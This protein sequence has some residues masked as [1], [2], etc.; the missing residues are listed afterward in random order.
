MKK[1]YELN[2]MK[3][4]RRGILPGLEEKDDSNIKVRITISLDKDILDY[5]KSLA[6]MPGGLPY[7]T[8]INQVLRKYIQT[9]ELDDIELIK[10]KLLNDPAFIKEIAKHINAA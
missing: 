5:F 10:S 6:A 2:K 9:G 3:L 1:E 4:K 7:Q 8:Q